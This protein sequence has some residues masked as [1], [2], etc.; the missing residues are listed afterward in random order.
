MTH[1]TAMTSRPEIRA[2]VP[3]A[4]GL[5]AF[6]V[7]MSAFG[8]W[9]KFTPVQANGTSGVTPGLGSRFSTVLVGFGLCIAVL[10]TARWK[11]QGAWLS[12]VLLV[13]FAFALYL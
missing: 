5:C 3:A 13:G 11:S 1:E 9:A 12:V 2:L 10:L 4:L 6:L 8:P 7:M